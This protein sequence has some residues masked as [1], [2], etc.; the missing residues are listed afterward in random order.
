[1]RRWLTYQRERFPLAA[2]VPL[3]AAFST[4][5]VCFSSLARG[6]ATFPPARALAVAFATS[7]LFFLQLRIADEFKDAEEDARWRPYRP[8]PRGLVTL[9]ELGWIAVAAA[10]VQVA[11]ALW[12]DPAL[13]WI[14]SC[15][16]LFVGLM[17]V[18]F[19][20]PRWLRER[21]AFYLATH[22]AVLPLI[23]L[24][25]TACDWYPAGVT[26][27]P[28]GLPLF[29]AV[30]Y[31]NGIVIEIG[32]KTRVPI[33][34]EPGVD[35]YSALWGQSRALHVWLAAVIVNGCVAWRASLVVGTAMPMLIL[36]GLLALACV[37]VARDV[38]ATNASGRGTR[39]EAMSGVWTICMY[40]GLGT[41]PLLLAVWRAR[42]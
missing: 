31:L 16:W 18:E 4:S 28:A 9:R 39:L 17:R 35:T 11:L 1:M 23:D 25:A 37:L 27:A 33:D 14:L 22:M 32:R 20:V 40:L 38:R 41:A 5:A 29:L 10:L 42:S 26:A 8:V 24:Y 2:H 6:A 21:P 13:I 7:L 12:L 15:A 19:F 34:E 3:V 30:S 36:L